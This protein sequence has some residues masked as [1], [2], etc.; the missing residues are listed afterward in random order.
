MEDVVRLVCYVTHAD[1][2]GDLNELF[3]QRFNEPRPTR[4]TVVVAGL[5]QDAMVELEATADL[6]S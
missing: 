3:T 2:M 5:P 4:T 6:R 1:Q